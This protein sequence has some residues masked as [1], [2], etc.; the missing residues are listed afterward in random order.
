MKGLPFNW[1]DMVLVILLLTGIAR[2]RK[3]GLSQ[4]LFTSMLWLVLIFACAAAY[5]PLGDMLARAARLSPLVSYILCYLAIAV[6]VA[7]LYSPVKR[8][9]GEK[10]VSADSFGSAE[11]YVGMPAGMVRFLCILIA[12]LAVLNARQYSTKEILA[13]QKFQQDNYGSEFFPGLNSVQQDVF[14]KSLT[15]P[16][17]K[18]YLGFLLIKPTKPEPSK[19]LRRAR[20]AGV[21]N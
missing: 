4:E 2:G 19:P 3:R 20:E 14:E 9:I 16:Y 11:Y 21:L 15:G 17:F 12:I 18:R 13:R 5:L 8:S 10:V 1:F 6:F 7:L